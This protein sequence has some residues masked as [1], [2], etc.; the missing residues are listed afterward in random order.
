MSELYLDH[1]AAVTDLD[2]FDGRWTATIV[3]ASP[4]LARQDGGSISLVVLNGM[5]DR[6]HV[7]GDKV[8]L[9][10]FGSDLVITSA[11]TPRPQYGIVGSVNTGTR[12]ATVTT[13]AGVWSVQYIGAAPTVADRVAMLWGPEGGMILGSASTTV[14]PPASTDP[15]AGA[16]G[17]PGGG[18]LTVSAAQA[19]TY[20][21][22]TR[23]TDVGTELR[24]GHWTTGIAAD[25]SGIF[26]F[27]DVFGG[28]AGKTVTSSKITLTRGPRGTGSDSAITFTIVAH[29]A[30]TLPGATP[31]Y[32]GSVTVSL[33][34]NETK[35]VDVT[36]IAAG[37]SSGTVRGFGISYA[38]TANYGALLGPDEIA[39][40]G[41]LVTIYA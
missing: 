16:P 27:G 36:S 17:A 39:G 3:S 24:Q 7:V 32:T 40:A 2:R 4:L 19:G 9:Q 29:A 14:T 10:R 5:P 37:L 21:S 11:L 6:Q 13:S 15:G 38:G 34:P 41:T 25:N 35:T 28:L 18:T 30:M 8:K 22:G 1:P 23:R 33:A 26:A 20:R 12:T 31:A